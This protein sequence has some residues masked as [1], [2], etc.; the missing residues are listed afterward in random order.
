M[1]NIT[2]IEKTKGSR[3]RK[4]LLSAFA[5]GGMLAVQW[6]TGLPVSWPLVVGVCVVCLGF[7]ST[8]I[9]DKALAS[10]ALGKLTN[11][12][13]GMGGKAEK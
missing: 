10:G 7:V 6:Q 9:L 13:P 3:V 4:L 8:D 2:E 11:K 1:I 5:I 12:I